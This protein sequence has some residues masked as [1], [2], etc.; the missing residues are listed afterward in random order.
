M[1]HFTKSIAITAAGILLAHSGKAGVFT[2]N[3]E[4]YSLG[5]GTIPG[6]AYTVEG[7]WEVTYDGSFAG[8]SQVAHGT[9][10]QRNFLVDLTPTTLSVGDSIWVQFDYRYTG[11]PTKS[12][13][14]NFIRFGLYGA[15]GTSSYTGDIGYQASLTYYKNG[16]PGTGGY[17]DLRY[18]NNTAPGGDIAGLLLDNMPG[19]LTA[20]SPSDGN[21]FASMLKTTD[22]GT[23]VHTVRLE[24][25]R[26]ATTMDLKLYHDNLTTPKL[27]GSATSG[28]GTFPVNFDQF[29]LESAANTSAG[30]SVNIDNLSIGSTAVPEPSEYAATAAIGLAGWAAWRRRRGA[31]VRGKAAGASVG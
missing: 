1:T 16:T 10:S 15:Q 9:A 26:G 29:V 21:S 28:I 24:I 18:E 5:S 20:G 19:V 11:A 25:Q 27:I 13:Q 12:A 7:F 17:Y 31:A 14:S 8:G 6:A 3:F 4:S 22:D 23:G 30:S 2:D